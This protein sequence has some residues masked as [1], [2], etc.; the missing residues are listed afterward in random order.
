M[1]DKYDE[2]KD[3]TEQLY[4]TIN[5]IIVPTERDKQQL[6]E[7]FKYIHDLRCIDSDYM[8]VNTLMHMYQAPQLIEVK[9]K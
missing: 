7:A 2:T 3:Q 8:A 4:V 9:N 1:L 6:L 5:K